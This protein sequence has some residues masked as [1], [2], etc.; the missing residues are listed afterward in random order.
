MSGNRARWRITYHRRIAYDIVEAPQLFD[1]QNRALLSVG[2]LERGRRFVVL[3]RNVAR[4]CADD[5]QSYFA[6]HGIDAK[7]VRFAGGEQRKRVDA[8]LE[9]L[10]ELDDFPIQRRDEPIIAIG[11]GVLTD[12]VGFV[13]SSYRR[14]VP[15]IKVPTTL[16]GYVDAS[17]GIKT[18]I[19]FNGHKNRL[20]SFEPPLRVLLD[21]EF[22]RTLPR[23]HILNGVCEILKL[24]IIK[25]AGL[26]R[27]LEEHGAESIDRRFQNPAGG[28]ILERAISGMLEELEPDLFEDNLSRKVDFGHTFSHGLESRHEARL[29]HGEA[30]LLDIA[31]STL[32]ARRRYLLSERETERIFRLIDALGLSLNIEL[33]DPELLWRALLERIEHRNGAQRSPMPDSLGHC[34]FLN[35]IARREIESAITALHERLCIHH[36]PALER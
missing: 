9:I 20:G 22:L 28:R 21:K 12:V 25:D 8:Y 24:A 1:P 31:V 33:L 30:V 16:M 14:G 26:F 32:I 36:E 27:L 4:H 29:L 17:V 7:I 34:V 18:A 5:L 23:R 10:R 15:H 6:H 11:G 19:N 2:R 3:D 13:A 35:D